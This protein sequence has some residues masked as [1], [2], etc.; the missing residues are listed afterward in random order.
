M[1]P[2]ILAVIVLALAFDF[3][4]GIHDS[5]NIVATMISSRAL[6]P[7]T[8]LSMTAV[9][10]FFGPLI[11]GVAVANTIGNEVIVAEAVNIQV[12]LA[13]LISAIF[14]NLFTWNLGFPSSSSHALIGGF[15]GAVVVGASW[16]AIKLAG[17]GK[18][19]IALFTSPL[20]GFIFGFFI[21][22]ST[23]LFAWNATPRINLLFKRSQIVTAI[24]LALSHGAN[25]AQKTM[26]IITLALVI[27]GYL[28]GFAVPSWVIFM[29]AGM[30]ALGTA[31]GGWKLIRTLGGK[32]YKIRP[33]DGMAVQLTS[34]LV[35][36][37]ASLV[38]GPVSTTQVVS[39]GIMGVGA[40]E[41]MNK[42]R[43]GVAKEIGAAWL[44]TIPATALVAAGTYWVI[45][46]ILP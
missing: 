28:N 42:V 25:D 10:E 7:R 4:N 12:L 16:H 44:L 15:I 45:I 31:L 43:W 29:C 35:I 18:V 32:F 37:G 34:A 41:R 23:F 5:S 2:P 40:A 6:S 36:L 19:L 14:W 39:S 13:A 3:L 21:L 20:I 24:A 38:G 26:G 30:I 11:F 46:Q 27:G 33:V 8:A 9:A 17:L 22:R 1:T